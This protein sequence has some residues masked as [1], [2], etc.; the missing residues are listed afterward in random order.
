MAKKRSAGFTSEG[1]SSQSSKDFIRYLLEVLFQVVEPNLF[2][3]E[4]V[5]LSASRSEIRDELAML[6]NKMLQ[7]SR[8][9]SACEEF[10]LS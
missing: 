5:D 8:G 6:P 3:V 4:L 2:L 9:W 1:F 7:G 10:G